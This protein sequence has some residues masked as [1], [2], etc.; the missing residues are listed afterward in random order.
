[1]LDDAFLDTKDKFNTILKESPL[2]NIISDEN[3]NVKSERILNMTVLTK[4]LHAFY[5]FSESAG[6]RQL[7]ATENVRWM[8]AKMLE[9]TGS[10]LRKIHSVTT[11]ICNLERATWDCLSQDPGLSHISYVPCDSH[12][13]QLLIKDLLS[14][15]EM[16]STFYKGLTIVIFLRKAKH[17]LGILRRYQTQHYGGPRS[18]IA[19]TILRW[20][21]QVTMLESVASNKT[22]LRS[23][24]EDPEAKFP[25]P[26][27]G[28]P[29]RTKEY[30]QDHEFWTQLD[31]LITILRPIHENQ[32]MPEA[33]DA[34]LDK[35]YIRWLEIQ[36]HLTAQSRH[37]RFHE[38]IITFLI[39]KFRLRLNKQINS[40]H[41]A[42]HYLHPINLHKRLDL[43]R[44][45]EILA[46]LKEYT[47]RP[48]H[49]ALETEFYDFREKSG[50]CAPHV[51]AW[52]N[53]E[54]PVLF[55]RKMVS[56]QS[57]VFD[58]II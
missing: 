1:M 9:L 4:N 53:G 44:Q 29:Y 11:D 38:E 39:E 32:K 22:A 7:D 8:L 55:W 14:T 37:N 50:V 16:K 19:S 21:T 47:P 51:D 57:L 34:T 42:A 23:Y 25:P 20:G 2:L 56:F 28:T 27:N 41:R 13:L 18:L 46:F 58:V 36:L 33:N 26:R 45:I 10:D 5:D 49:A 52:E 54:G 6:D 12:E 17:R 35:V 40:A 31:E 30:V 43:L 48:K 24:V 3:N 15:P